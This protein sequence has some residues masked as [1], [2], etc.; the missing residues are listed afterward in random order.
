M[1]A[2]SK[3][4]LFIALAIALIAILLIVSVWQLT[5]INK[6][7]KEL[8]AKQVE[9]QRLTDLVDYYKEHKGN[10]TSDGNE[11]IESGENL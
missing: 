7:Q 10:P 6:K 5:E 4:K 8:N 3:V 1:K 11:L 9:V 2:N